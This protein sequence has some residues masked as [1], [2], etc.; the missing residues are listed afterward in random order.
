MGKGK[1]PCPACS[2]DS[3]GWKQLAAVHFRCPGPF[4]RHRHGVN[5][6][7]WHRRVTAQ[8]PRG[9]YHAGAGFAIPVW[10]RGPRM[11][12]DPVREERQ[13]RL[14]D[15]KTETQPSPCQKRD[16]VAAVPLNGASA[17]R[18]HAGLLSFVGAGTHC[19]SCDAALWWRSAWACCRGRYQ[20]VPSSGQ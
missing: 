15:R 7:M 5:V 6:R 2:I 18:R 13:T 20:T 10:L 11:Q 14:S 4:D 1:L 16:V 3:P 12:R 17:R 8:L 9:W 19:R